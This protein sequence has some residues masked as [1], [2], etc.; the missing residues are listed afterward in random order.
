[1]RTLGDARSGYDIMEAQSTFTNWV[2]ANI[3]YQWN[4]SLWNSGATTTSNSSF[5]ATNFYTGSAIN[6]F[7]VTNGSLWG[8]TTTGTANISGLLTNVTSLQT[9][10][11]QSN[12][13]GGYFNV[14]YTGVNVSSLINKAMAQN[15][16][17][18]YAVEKVTQKNLTGVNF[19]SIYLNNITHYMSNGTYQITASKSGYYNKTV[20]I[21]AT[22]LQ[23]VSQNISYV[24]NHTLNITAR[25]LFTN[26]IINTFNVRVIST[27]YGY[28]ETYSTTNG[29]IL[30]NTTSVTLTYE[31]YATG[32]FNKT[33]TLTLTGNASNNTIVL[34]PYGGLQVRFIRA[35]NGS[36]ITSPVQTVIFQNSTTSISFT[37]V[38]GTA[39]VSGLSEDTYQVLCQVTGFDNNSFTYD[40]PA[41]TTSLPDAFY[42]VMSAGTTQITYQVQSP[43]LTP[44]ANVLVQV[45]QF[46]NGSYITVA[47]EYTDGTGQ[48]V[49]NLVQGLTT[50]VTLSLAGYTTQVN[51][52]NL[53]STT[54]TYT[55]DPVNRFDP[56]NSAGSSITYSFYPTQFDL[57]LSVWGFT[58]NVTPDS[59][60][61]LEYFKITIANING[62]T[63]TSF[64]STNSSGGNITIPFNT[65]P[66]NGSVLRVTY[67]FKKT[68]N[69]EYSVLVVYNIA[70]RYVTGS[71]VGARQYILANFDLGERIFLWMFLTIVSALL[72][73]ALGIKD[74]LNVLLVSMIW[75]GLAYVFAM[76]M[77]IVGFIFFLL[78]LA[79]VRYTL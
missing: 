44:L 10:S 76:N 36:I 25:D 17:T 66:Y 38:N 67:S 26:A 14:T 78:F 55:L 39:N 47:S 64:T 28:D 4:Y 9:I 60:T 3:N 46:V 58:L 51:T 57:N 73:S 2:N 24:G 27:T 5:T 42:C 21:T 7:C 19:T 70:D 49:M 20:P 32:Y 72:L 6:S 75:L 13:S 59:G 41:I 53:D 54:Y 31:A 79:I 16:Y 63:L 48:S 11:Y 62:T 35:S 52:N 71:I 61:L 37:G 15:S 18:F 33:G 8:C 77:V 23:T 22:T 43:D 56:S 69:T 30:D 68:D 40:Y 65:A 74:L 12:E 50:R 29:I 45:E 34:N 1:M